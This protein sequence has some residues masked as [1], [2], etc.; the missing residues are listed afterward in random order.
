LKSLVKK[1]QLDK[2]NKQWIDIN[3][4]KKKD[5]DFKNRESVYMPFDNKWMNSLKIPP[6]IIL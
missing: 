6:N 4:Q 5:I 1:K 3:I 2:L